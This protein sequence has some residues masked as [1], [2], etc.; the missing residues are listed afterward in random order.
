MTSNLKRLKENKYLLLV[1]KKAPPKLRRAILQSAP[2]ELIRAINEIAYNILKGNHKISRKSRNDLKKY[3]NQLRKLIKPSRSVTTKR[4][5]LVQSG[6]SFLPYLLSA[7]L[8]G[9]IGKIL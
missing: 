1:L 7:V 4:K 6:G 5:V 3:K 8:S 9:I 2:D